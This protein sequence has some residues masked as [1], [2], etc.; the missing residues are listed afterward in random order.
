MLCQRGGSKWV[1]VET[2]PKFLLRGFEGPCFQVPIREKDGNGLPEKSVGKK[3]EKIDK[4]T[5]I[6]RGCAGKNRIFQGRLSSTPR[7]SAERLGSRK[8]PRGHFAG[9]ERMKKPKKSQSNWRRKY[10]KWGLL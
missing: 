3:K 7:G 1:K 10:K 6:D 8:G 4:E 5:G 2:F 9:G